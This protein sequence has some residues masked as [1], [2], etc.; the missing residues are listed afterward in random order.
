[1][2]RH[3]P[4]APAMIFCLL[5]FCFMG[6]SGGPPDDVKQMIE[7]TKKQ[8][9]AADIQAAVRPLFSKFKPDEEIPV[10]QL[11]KEITSLPLFSIYSN[12][13]ILHVNRL[14]GDTNALE[15]WSGGGFGHWGII[16]CRFNNDQ[17]LAKVFDSKT[18]WLSR[19]ED[20]VFFIYGP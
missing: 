3:H 11:P 5:V 2:K 10:N 19:W 9:K 18:F 20:G 8:S 16:V 13:Q 14:N 12:Q 17:E 7:Q 4:F 1:M 6:C 15:F